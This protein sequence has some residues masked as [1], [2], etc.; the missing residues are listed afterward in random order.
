MAE[1]ITPSW[2]KQRQCKYEPAGADTL[3]KVTGP[4]LG[5]A[6]IRVERTGNGR[7]LAA[8]RTS[9]DGPDV[10]VTEPNIPS[11]REAWDAAFELYRQNV[12]V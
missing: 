3:M 6:Y 12:I 2:F 11:E 4:N 1:L 7:W 5:E 10:A 9:A 8:F